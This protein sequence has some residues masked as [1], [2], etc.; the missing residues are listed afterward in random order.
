MV[1]EQVAREKEQAR[2][3]GK[4]PAELAEN[5]AEYRHHLQH[6]KGNN[7]ERHQSQDRRIDQGDLEPLPEVDHA[8]GV[9]RQQRQDPRQV[10]R[11]LARADEGGKHTREVR[12]LPVDG[13]VQRHALLQV[14]V[15][16]L[17]HRLQPRVV[18]FRRQR[19]EGRRHGQPPAHNGLQLLREQLQ[20]RPGQRA[21][22]AQQPPVRIRLLDGVHREAPLLQLPRHRVRGR[23]LHTVL[24]RVPVGIHRPVFVRRHQSFPRARCG[25]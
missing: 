13:L 2:G 16:P 19:L 10:A 15:Q 24:D 21:R 6:E 5:I 22:S 1:L 3:P 25:L 8:R 4:L 20:V 18:Q 14:H 23:G 17:Q 9:R 12:V 7:G 11:G